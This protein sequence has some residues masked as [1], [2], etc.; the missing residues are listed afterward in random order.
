MTT[1]DFYFSPTQLDRNDF[2]KDTIG[3]FTSFH[4]SGG[5]P[6]ID[7]VQIAIFGV[8][9]WRGNAQ[10]KDTNNKDPFLA[11]RNELY[12]LFHHQKEISIVDLGNIQPGASLQDTYHAVADVVFELGKKKIVA[13]LLGGSQDITFANYKGYEKLE[14]TVNLSVIDRLI[15]MGNDNEPISNANYL[16]KIILHQPNYLFNFSC[17]GYQTYFISPEIKKLMSD[18]FFD[19]YR[20][21]EM[22]A[23][24]AHSESVLRNAD[25]ISVDVSSIR[26][27]EFQAK[28]DSEPNGFYGE[29]ICQ[30][31]RY[32]GMSDK[33]SSIGIYE[34]SAKDD[35]DG[36]SAKL[37]AQMVWCF[38]DGYCSRKKDYPMGT[39]ETYIK[40]RIDV[41]NTDHELIFYKSDRSDR[42]WMDVPYPPQEYLKFERHHLV[43]CNY[44]DYQLASQ[45]QIPDLWWQTYQKLN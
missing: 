27:S 45:G 4:N 32:A 11:I 1:I 31:M 39:K 14:Q 29:E 15:D 5:F 33:L 41:E 30:M 24:M 13:L 43:P 9:E 19:T 7:G 21:G 12:Q 16:S 40:Y 42:W 22:Q 6:D 20:L 26:K 34:Y 44:E 3:Y 23:K 36:A 37:A 38:I 8:N 25:I 17:V 18:L 35:R 28:L 10:Y 2:A